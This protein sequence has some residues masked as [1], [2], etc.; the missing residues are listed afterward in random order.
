MV[1]VMEPLRDHRNGAIHKGPLACGRRGA[2]RYREKSGTGIDILID[3]NCCLAPRKGETTMALK[4][5]ILAGNTRLEQAF[6][7]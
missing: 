3:S 5:R 7:G 6:A 2:G 4:S 1:T